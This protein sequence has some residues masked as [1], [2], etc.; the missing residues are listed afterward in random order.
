MRRCRVCGE[1]FEALFSFCPIDGTQV[2]AAFSEAPH[3]E[4]TLT[5]VSDVGLI[6]RL[7]VELNF[8]IEQ[9]K[10]AWPSFRDHPVAFATNQLSQLWKWLAQI[11]GRQHV[12]SGLMTA[13]LLVSS[14]ILSVLLLEKHSA[15]TINQAD[16]DDIAETVRIDF[17]D[18]TTPSSDPGVGAGERGRVGF[19]RGSGEG[20]RPVPAR[21]KGGGSGGLHNQS[22]ASQG[23]L[24]QPSVIPAPIPTVFARMPPALPAAGLDIDPALWRN[25][26]YAAYGDPRSKSTT[27]SNGPGDGGG[28]GNG[29]GTGIGEG[30][31]PGFGRGKNGNMGGRDKSLGGGEKGGAAGDEPNEPDRVYSS[32][33]VTTRARVLSKP[34][35]QYT[36]E[37]RRNQITG[38]VILRVVF[39][40]SG[41]VTNIRAIQTLSDGLT[42]KALQFVLTHQCN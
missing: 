23:R 32:P 42:E 19:E 24:P 31:G 34:E 33:E 29:N 5:I 13:I 11:L 15:R 10:Q 41:E 26:N 20:S 30:D 17:Q 37:A 36:E 16:T 39:S 9:F 40:R 28:I 35:P 3:S 4:F 8:L 21:A 27:A 22:L 14:I 6:Q 12:L 25:L 7:A 1:Q 2:G 18:A 38:T